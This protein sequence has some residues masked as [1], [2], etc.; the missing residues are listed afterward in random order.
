M[1]SRIV[2]LQSLFRKSPQNTLG[3]KISKLRIG[4]SPG[5]LETG[6]LSHDLVMARQ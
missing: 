1:A 6:T 2:C 4:E 3:L 5:N